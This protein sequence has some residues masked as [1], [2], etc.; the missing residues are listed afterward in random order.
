MKLSDEKAAC[1]LSLS[2]SGIWSFGALLESGIS[3]VQFCFVVKNEHKDLFSPLNH[4]ASKRQ[5]ICST[6]DFTPQHFSSSCGL[7]CHFCSCTELPHCH[8][9]AEGY[10]AFPFAVTQDVLPVSLAKASWSHQ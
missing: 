7:K 4:S 10:N 5:Q 9:Y 3:L 6:Q 2:F 8:C 1:P